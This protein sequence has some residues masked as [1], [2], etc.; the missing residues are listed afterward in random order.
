[1]KTVT[2]RDEAPVEGLI[3]QARQ[4]YEGKLTYSANWDEIEQ[5]E[6]W[7]RLDF[8]GI[9]AFFPLTDKT[10]ATP[11]DLRAGAVALAEELA[12]LQRGWGKPVLFTEVGYK[13]YPDAAIRPWEWPQDVDPADVDEAYQAAAY[14]AIF[15]ALWERPWFAGMFWWKSFTDLH[16]REE[17]PWGFTPI[18]KQAQDVM[19]RRYRGQQGGQ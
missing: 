16:A 3:A 6:F 10:G 2:A 4:R 18:G 11:A 8:V 13:S 9:N 5:V 19:A 17:E 1:M 7:P 12:R 14:E 15:A